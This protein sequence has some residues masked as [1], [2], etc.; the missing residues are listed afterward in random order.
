MG[1][2]GTDRVISMLCEYI[3]KQLGHPALDCV[4]ITIYKG[5]NTK[6]GGVALTNGRI[7]DWGLSIG[8]G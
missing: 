8:N 4:R 2:K 7:I 3:C 6:D 1:G 5:A